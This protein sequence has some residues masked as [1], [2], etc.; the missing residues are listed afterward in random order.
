MGGRVFVSVGPT[1][2]AEW[3]I[4]EGMKPTVGALISRE[5]LE[6]YGISDDF[7]VWLNGREVGDQAEVRDGDHIEIRPRT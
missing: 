5:P 1:W 6:A 4:P 2:R 3:P 7:A